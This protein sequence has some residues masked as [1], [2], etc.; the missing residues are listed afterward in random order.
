MPCLGFASVGAMGSGYTQPAR[1]TQCN[2]AIRLQ[3]QENMGR[4][5]ELE[6]KYTCDGPDAP[7]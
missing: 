4:F 1:H 7:V 5:F 6:C 2:Q 3:I